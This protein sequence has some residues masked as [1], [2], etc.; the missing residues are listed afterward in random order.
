MEG[1]MFFSLDGEQIILREGDSI[2]FKSERPHRWE[3]SGDK[4]LKFLWVMTPLPLSSID[5]WIP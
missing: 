3:N 4:D 1:E 2:H 5:R